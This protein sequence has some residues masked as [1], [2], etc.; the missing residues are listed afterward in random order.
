[1]CGGDN[2]LLGKMGMYSDE[3][4]TSFQR[5]KIDIPKKKKK[6]ILRLL[7]T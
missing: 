4:R 3:K 2:S 7:V 1:M 5:V 6:G